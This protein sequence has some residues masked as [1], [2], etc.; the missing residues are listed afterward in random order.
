MSFDGRQI[1][2]F[3]LDFGDSK[4]RPISHLCL[5]KIIYFCH[6]WSLVEL[7]QPLVREKFAAWKYGPVLQNLYRQFESCENYPIHQRATVLN[8]LTGIRE[9]AHYMFDS[10]IEQFLRRTLEVYT[11]LTSTELIDLAHIPNGPWHQVWNHSGLSN[12][13]MLIDN[14]RILSF[15]LRG[16]A[17]TR[18]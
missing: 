8:P 16:G 13:G 9:V 2:N 17:V 12:P 11:R 6:V 18:H 7:G 1:A 10:A 3:S 15:Y 14:E 5:H 4:G